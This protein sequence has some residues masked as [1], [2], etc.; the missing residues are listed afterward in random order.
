MATL[1]RSGR[2]A[3]LLVPLVGAAAPVGAW[4]LLY[5]GFHL[6]AVH[7]AFEFELVETIETGLDRASRGP[8]PLRLERLVAP[9][10]LL[11]I[12]TIQQ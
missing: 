2:A 8:S 1:R 10:E 4:C 7:A 9:S 12:L 3:P 11:K 5:Y 6:P